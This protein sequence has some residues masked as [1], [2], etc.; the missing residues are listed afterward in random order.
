MEGFQQRVLTNSNFKEEPVL[1]RFRDNLTDMYRFWDSIPANCITISAMEL[2]NGSAMEELSTI[3]DMELRDTAH[4]WPYY[5]RKKTGAAAAYAFMIFPR[6]S[7]PDISVY[8]QAM[9]DLCLFINLTN[10]IL[11]FH[12]EYLARETNNY[13]HNRA[14]VNRKSIQ[15]TLHDVARDALAAHARIMET[16]R[17]T[18]G[19]QWKRFVNG[20]L[21]VHITQARYRLNDL[22]F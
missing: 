14:Y 2:L 11:S 1:H 5:L 22:G 8:I 12:K 3:R 13:I 10:D 18:D 9:G 17:F 4:S 7:N 21:A 19:I 20:Y 16:L 15:D 6:D